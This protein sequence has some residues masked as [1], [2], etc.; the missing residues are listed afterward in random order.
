MVLLAT[1]ALKPAARNIKGKAVMIDSSPGRQTGT[2]LAAA[3][4]SWEV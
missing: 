2:C 1:A 4:A 3:R